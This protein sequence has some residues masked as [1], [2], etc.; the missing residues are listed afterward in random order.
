MEQR[1]ANIIDENML[2]QVDSEGHHH[3]V[4]TEVTEH[5]KDDSAISKVDGFIKSS[6]GKLRWKR[7]TREWKLLVEFKD[8]SVDWVPLK[9]LEQSNPVDLDEYAV[10][11]E[12]SDE[13]AFS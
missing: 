11:N 13:P 2:S 12:I 3:Q 7:T 9:Y 4:L 1:A 8:G 10:G 5:K 6:S